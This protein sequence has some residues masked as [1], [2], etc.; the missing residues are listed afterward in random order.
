[1]RALQKFIA[2]GAITAMGMG[3]GWSQQ[4]RP[5]IQQSTETQSQ[6]TRQ[7]ETRSYD[8][9]MRPSPETR[10]TETRETR[11]SGAESFRASTLIGSRVTNHQG[12]RL[13]NLSDL[14]I[15]LES[16]ELAYVIV[17]AGGLV[18]G[19]GGELRPVPADRF[20]VQAM[21]NLLGG[22]ELI[23]DMDM[24]RWD[25]APSIRQNELAKLEQ[26]KMTSDIRE[27]Y[28]Q[29]GGSQQ[30]FGSSDRPE[31]AESQAE[32]QAE[33]EAEMQAEDNAYPEEEPTQ[34]GAVPQER[35]PEQAAMEQPEYRQEQSATQQQTQTSQ[36]ASAESTQRAEMSSSA[37]AEARS[38][39]Q[40]EQA[41]RFSLASDLI[42]TDVRNEQQ[43]A[44]GE[45]EDLLVN[46]QEGQLSHV[47][48]APARESFWQMPMENYAIRPDSLNRL[49]ENQLVLSLS[50]EQLEDADVVTE[51]E[52]QTAQLEAEAFRVEV[53]PGR[54]V[55]YGGREARPEP[56]EQR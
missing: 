45:I 50:K 33:T 46:L 54:P 9:E 30:Q 24:E 22:V 1:M 15:D 47:T 20:Q 43:E 11:A 39:E 48:I 34:F 23:M 32:I 18:G 38:A 36:S 51:E 27:F 56:Q 2:A 8:P 40:S 53:E 26:E 31:N 10:Q 35:S 14:V 17:S 7:L 16:G 4:D 19:F 37:A 6:E 25:R 21:E 44:V 29:G 5:Q 52:L 28:G 41:S 55:V 13:G 12:E 42:G 3:S 49:N